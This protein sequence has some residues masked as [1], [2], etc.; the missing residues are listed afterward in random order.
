MKEGNK[1]IFYGKL[2]LEIGLQCKHVSSAGLILGID[3]LHAD[4]VLP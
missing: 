2:T 4:I 3:S 1:N